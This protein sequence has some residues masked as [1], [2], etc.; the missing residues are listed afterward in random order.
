MGTDGAPAAAAPA[1]ADGGGA[2]AAAS[3]RPPGACART[4]AE[5]GAVRAHA[6]GPSSPPQPPAA[7]A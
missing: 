3:A 5:A 1:A 6:P 4:Q 2:A 7:A